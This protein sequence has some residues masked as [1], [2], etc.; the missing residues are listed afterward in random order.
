MIPWLRIGAVA[1]ALASPIDALHA[2][3]DPLK[4]QVLVGFDIEAP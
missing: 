4:P 3:P 1:L 2:E